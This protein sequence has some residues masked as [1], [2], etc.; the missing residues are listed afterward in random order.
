MVQYMQQHQY[1]FLIAFDKLGPANVIDNH[2]PNVF[3]SML[4]R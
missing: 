1:M 4:L 2:I 3:A